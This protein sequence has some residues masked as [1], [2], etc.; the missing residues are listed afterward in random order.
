MPWVDDILNGLQVQIDKL[1]YDLL[2]LLAVAGWTLQ[3]GLFMM[4]HAIE[5]ANLWLA[6]NAF[7]PLI[8]QTNH[9]MR[10]TA[11]LALNDRPH[12]A[13]YH[14]LLAAFVRLD[15]V[16]PRSALA[17][18]WRAWCSFQ[19]GPTSTRNARFPPRPGFGYNVALESMQ[20]VGSPFGSL[21]P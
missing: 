15:V 13:G 11:S 17:S 2:H 18:T 8:S 19:L 20:S 3:K 14:H 12:R 1:W 9:Q 5:L 4:G 6:Q 21:R 7:A 16:S 10:V